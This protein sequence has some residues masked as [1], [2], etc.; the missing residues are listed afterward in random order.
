M[1][2]SPPYYFSIP[3][4]L[5]ILKSTVTVKTM[6]LIECS[7]PPSYLHGHKFGI[8]S[9][10]FGYCP[11]IEYAV[12]THYVEHYHKYRGI[13]Q[14]NFLFCNCCQFCIQQ[15]GSPSGN[16]YFFLSRPQ[17]S[18]SPPKE[19]AP[20][21]GPQAPPPQENSTSAGQSRDFFRDAINTSGI[22]YVTKDDNLADIPPQQV[23]KVDIL[24]LGLPRLS[25]GRKLYMLHL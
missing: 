9:F 19:A 11:T 22:G 4:V 25:T 16:S 5:W 3:F 15:I 23:K 20:S 13:I 14:T 10:V 12:V 17:P 18:D 21:I 7:I 1:L 2:E 8:R 24:S 6:N